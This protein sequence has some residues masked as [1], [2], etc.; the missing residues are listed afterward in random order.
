M[1]DYLFDP[2]FLPFTFALALLFGLAGLELVALLIGASF[3]GSGE[4]DGDL[5]GVDGIDGPDVPELGDFGGD[6]SLDADAIGDLGDLDLADIDG[7]DLSEG[8]APV[9]AAGGV[10]GW[11]GLGKMPMLIWL[12]TLLLG[13]GLSGIG[14]Q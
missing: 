3:L 2:D 10:S 1:F 6:L 11:L 5:G 9:E 4:A 8:S 7:M 12:A 14:L 13:F